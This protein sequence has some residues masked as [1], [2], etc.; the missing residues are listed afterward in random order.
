VEERKIKENMKG[1]KKRRKKG[2]EQEKKN[3]QE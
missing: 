2:K 1:K 3:M